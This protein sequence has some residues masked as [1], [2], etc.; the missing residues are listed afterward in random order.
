MFISSRRRTAMHWTSTWFL[1]AGVIALACFALSCVPAKPPV[2]TPAL[3]RVEVPLVI[4][5]RTGTAALAATFKWAPQVEEVRWREGIKWVSDSGT[6]GR[7][8]GAVIL[9]KAAWDTVAFVVSRSDIPGYPW[10]PYA[11]TVKE[12]T[13]G[14][15]NGYLPLSPESV[16]IISGKRKAVP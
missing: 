11:V 2:V 6:K 15:E 16:T 5:T 14:K 8:G 7:I 3:Q 4:V 12:T 9:V 10:T 13:S 1:V